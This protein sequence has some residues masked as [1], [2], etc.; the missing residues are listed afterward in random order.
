MRTMPFETEHLR[1]RPL[2]EEDA[3]YL[4]AMD[5]DP[6]V[7]RYI[8][9]TF[10]PPESKEGALSWIRSMHERYYDAGSRYGVFAAIEKATEDFIGWFILRPALHYRFAKEAQFAETELELGYRF[11][12]KFWGR[13]YG[14]EGSLAL[15][16]YAR[17]DDEIT[18]IVAIALVANRASTRVMEKA[19]LSLSG[20]CPLPGYAMDAVTYRL[21]LIRSEIIG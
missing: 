13:G 21:P 17:E 14:T 4:F 8:S 20:S 9:A 11:L 3:E 6:E 12:R 19:G 18:A 1:L 7:M 5:S 10:S 2:R 15:V 16:E